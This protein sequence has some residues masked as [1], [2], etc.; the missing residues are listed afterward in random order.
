MRNELFPRRP[1][2]H[3]P[4]QSVILV[5][6]ACRTG[7]SVRFL[8]FADLRNLRFFQRFALVNLL[9]MVLNHVVGVQTAR[10]VGILVGRW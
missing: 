8:S 2:S 1:I 4:A 5:A 10:Y 7:Q 3:I 6:R 9:T